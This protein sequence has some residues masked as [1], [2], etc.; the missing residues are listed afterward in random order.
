MT[1]E[2]LIKQR[3]KEKTTEIGYKLWLENI[4]IKVISS[5]SC[6][7]IQIYFESEFKANVCYSQF[8]TLINEAAKDITKSKVKTEWFYYDESECKSL[9][10]DKKDNSDNETEID[11]KLKKLLD[12]IS[13]N[14]KY[15]TIDPFVFSFVFNDLQIF[16]VK[17][18]VI[19]LSFPHPF[20]CKIVQ[21]YFSKEV[22]QSV[23]DV[24][25]KNM[26]IQY[27]V[28]GDDYSNND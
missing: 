20:I 10:R 18:D 8:K 14:Y 9:F 3:L 6:S 24:F 21:T 25:N 12:N 23:D 28:Q 17:D 1:I 7:V 19:Q 11:K 13:N 15:S 2:E 5:D 16:A 26:K 4:K 27:T 22:K